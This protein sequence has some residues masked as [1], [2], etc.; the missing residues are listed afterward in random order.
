MKFMLFEEIGGCIYKTHSDAK[1]IDDGT[2][3]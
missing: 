1:F 2:R 3:P